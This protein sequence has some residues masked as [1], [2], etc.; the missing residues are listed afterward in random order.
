MLT[1]PGAIRGQPLLPVL[2]AFR[3]GSVSK[4]AFQ[5]AEASSLPR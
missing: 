5:R 4:R 2:D 1:K 3:A